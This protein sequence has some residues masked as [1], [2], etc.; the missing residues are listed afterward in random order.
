MTASG[1]L[2]AASAGNSI[3]S[4]CTQSPARATTAFTTAASDRFAN[5]AVFTNYR[6]CVDG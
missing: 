4:A 2:I 5:A 6:E 3:T 1:V